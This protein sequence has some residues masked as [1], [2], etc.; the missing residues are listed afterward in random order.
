MKTK[1]DE[2]L[3]K[4]VQEELT[5]VNQEEVYEDMLR[6]MY[7]DV[8]VCGM[9]MDA[10]DV[11]K[12]YDPIA[13]RCGMNDYFGTTDEYTEIAGELYLTEEVDELREQIEAEQEDT[14]ETEGE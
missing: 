5:A 14:D 13:F 8:D 1:I 11:L 9:S 3:E 10:A 2:I 6:E 12:R 7:G 4:R